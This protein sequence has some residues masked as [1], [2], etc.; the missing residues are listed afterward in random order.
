MK[1]VKHVFLS[2]D[3]FGR[4]QNRNKAIDE[5]FKRGFIKSAGLIVT[6]KYLQDAVNYINGGG[7]VNHIHCHFNLSGNIPGEDSQD[8]PLTGRMAK[9]QLFCSNGLFKSPSK[10]PNRPKDILKLFV[11][12]RELCAQYDKFLL[13]TKGEGNN[14]HIDF[15]LWYN[16]SLPVSLALNLFT[17]TH[18]IKTVRYIGIHQLHTKRILFRILSWNPFVKSYR[19]SNIDGYL[20]HPNWFKTKRRFELYCHPD[21][22]DGKL[23]DNSISYFGYEKQLMETNIELLRSNKDLEF[24]SWAD[25]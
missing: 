23:M 3:D 24:V 9:E 11:V 6:G 8:I 7:Y 17:W 12:Y 4:S 18:G 2:A 21:Y 14:K 5:S 25:L 10:Y 1:Q 19:S 13:V 16:L 22:C 20:T 15:H